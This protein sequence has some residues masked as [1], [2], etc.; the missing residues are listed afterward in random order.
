[1]TNG[2][3]EKIDSINFK[4][5]RKCKREKIIKSTNGEDEKKKAIKITNREDEKE[6]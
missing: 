5:V 4:K 1:M 2:E 6:R 3:D